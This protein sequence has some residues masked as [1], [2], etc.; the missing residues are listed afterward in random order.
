MARDFD[1]ELALLEERVK[2][3]VFLLR[4]CQYGVEKLKARLKAEA[5]APAPAQPANTDTRKNASPRSQSRT[6]VMKAR[7]PPTSPER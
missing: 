2:D 3:A 6:A 4:D 1:M 7:S 5:P